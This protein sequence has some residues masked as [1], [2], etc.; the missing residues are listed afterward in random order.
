ML[1]KMLKLRVAGCGAAYTQADALKAAAVTVG[2]TLVLVVALTW[3][4]TRYGK[5]PYL[6]SLL[7]VSWMLPM[8][9]SQRYTD[10]KGRSGR[11]QVVLIG[12]SAAFVLAMALGA[13]WISQ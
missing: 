5:N 3:A 12:G 9:F 7:L 8:L 11:V 6:Q 10:W 13:T 2:G 4:I 1:A